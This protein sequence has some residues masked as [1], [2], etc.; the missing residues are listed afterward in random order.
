MN[1]LI[2]CRNLRTSYNF[3]NPKPGPIEALIFTRKWKLN[4]KMQELFK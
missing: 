2:V 4:W 3:A 1:R